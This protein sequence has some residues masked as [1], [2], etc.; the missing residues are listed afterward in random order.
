[1]AH[2]GRNLG[3]I[4]IDLRGTR[5]VDVCDALEPSEGET[6][7]DR[8]RSS[9][10]RDTDPEERRDIR[11]VIPSEDTASVTPGF[12]EGALDDFRSGLGQFVSGDEP[13]EDLARHPQAVPA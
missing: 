5:D 4:V 13:V 1:M 12:H 6:V 8:T 7:I 2:S 9:A 10:F 3:L 11:I